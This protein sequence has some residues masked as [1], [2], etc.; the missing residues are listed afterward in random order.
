MAHQKSRRTALRVK[1]TA[2]SSRRWGGM[3]NYASPYALAHSYFSPRP[4]WPCNPWSAIYQREPRQWTTLAGRKANQ[5]MTAGWDKRTLCEAARVAED[6]SHSHRGA[7]NLSAYGPISGTSRWW[8]KL[9]P[10][11][12]VV[13]QAERVDQEPSIHRGVGES[14]NGGAGRDDAGSRQRVLCVWCV[15]GKTASA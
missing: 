14:S 5:P 12:A 7:L 3:H 9:R 8:P 11:R 10:R 1:W 2:P 6:N 15:V 4:T 13:F